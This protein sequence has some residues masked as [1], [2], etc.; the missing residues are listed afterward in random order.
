MTQPADLRD[1]MIP[2]RYGV[3]RPGYREQIA[4]DVVQMLQAAAYNAEA[5]GPIGAVIPS[6]GLWYVR[7]DAS[8]D[9]VT[10]AFDV[11]GITL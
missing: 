4:R 11:L 7:T 9:S 6:G 1:Y 8:E 3:N 5:F 10:R 2:T